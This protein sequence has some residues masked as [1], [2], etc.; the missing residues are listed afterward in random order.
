[1]LLELCDSCLK[2]GLLQS[3]GFLV[4]IDL[5][6]RHKVVQGFVWVLGDD[7]VD[8]GSRVL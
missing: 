1:L 8:L 4:G 5:L 3:L 6:L 7:G 2:S